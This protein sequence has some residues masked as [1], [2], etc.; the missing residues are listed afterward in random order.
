MKAVTPLYHILVH[1]VVILG[2]PLQLRRVIRHEGMGEVVD[3]VVIDGTE[4]PWFAFHQS[5]R[6]GVHRGIVT[7]DLGEGAKPLVLLLIDL[8][9]FGNKRQDMSLRKF[10]R[11]NSEPRQLCASLVWMDSSLWH[12]PA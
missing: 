9:R 11:K 6:D 2:N 5:R 7:Q 3:A 1:G 8:S 12:D 4:I 10:V